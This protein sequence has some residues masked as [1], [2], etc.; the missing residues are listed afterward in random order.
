MVFVVLLWG[1]GEAQVCAESGGSWVDCRP[2]PPVCQD[3]QLVAVRCAGVCVQGCNC[4]A[5]APLWDEALGCLPASACAA[6][7]AEVQ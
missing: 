4:P 2:C 7:I 6:G 5:E 3:G 1:C